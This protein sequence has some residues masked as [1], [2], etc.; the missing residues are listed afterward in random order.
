MTSIGLI[1]LTTINLGNDKVPL[2]VFEMEEELLDP[3]FSM[4]SY[5]WEPPA[6]LR[7]VLEKLD[8]SGVPIFS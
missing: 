8:I 3:N 6:T 5:A 4:E 7:G 1:E 2:F